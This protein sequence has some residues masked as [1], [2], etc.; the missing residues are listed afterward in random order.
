LTE[1]EKHK[2]NILTGQ[3]ESRPDVFYFFPNRT[4]L[5]T[6]LANRTNGTFAFAPVAQA[7]PSAKAKE[8]FFATALIRMVNLAI[9]ITD[10]KLNLKLVDIKTNGYF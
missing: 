6:I 7:D 9:N 2:D 1:N 4:F 5:K 3:R 8:P 10:I